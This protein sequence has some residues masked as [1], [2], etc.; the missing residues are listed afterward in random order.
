MVIISRQALAPRAHGVRVQKVTCSPRDFRLS[1]HVNVVDPF[2][3]ACLDFLYCDDVTNE[4]LP[5]KHAGGDA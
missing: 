2:D 3:L 1:D 5:K 4:R